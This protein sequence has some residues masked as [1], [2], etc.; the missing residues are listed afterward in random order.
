MRVGAGGRQRGTQIRHREWRR[1]RRRRRRSHVVRSGLPLA[2]SE[3]ADTQLLACRSHR[4]SS[5]RSISS[6][7]ASVLSSSPAS[8][9]V[10]E[11]PLSLQNPGQLQ[12]TT[13][14]SSTIL[15]SPLL[16]AP[17][18]R[19]HFGACPPPLQPMLPADS[20]R[21]AER[22]IMREGRKR[23]GRRK[24]EDGIWDPQFFVC[25]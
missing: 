14:V 25:E 8:L 3:H 2:L 15:S 20:R 23:G 12:P 10:L 11:R 18:G 9:L 4:L 19:H 6:A 22:E 5:P 13:A 7:S 24:R 1:R 16:L 21:E 17:T